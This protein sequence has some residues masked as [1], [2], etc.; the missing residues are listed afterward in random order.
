VPFTAQ[1]LT[2]GHAPG[3]KIR[4]SELIERAYRNEG[5][6]AN[7]VLRMTLVIDGIKNTL[8][9]NGIQAQ[10]I[11]NRGN[12]EF[13]VTQSSGS[14][15][16]YTLLTLPP[17]NVFHEI[18]VGSRLFRGARKSTSVDCIEETFPVTVDKKLQGTYSFKFISAAGKGLPTDVEGTLVL[19]EKQLCING[20]NIESGYYAAPVDKDGVG[21]IS[22]WPTAAKDY[23]YKLSSVQTSAT[24]KL[25]SLVAVLRSVQLA[26]IV[27]GEPSAEN[28]GALTAF[29]KISDV[30]TCTSTVIFS[31]VSPP[32]PTLTANE[33]SIFDLAAELI[34]AMF[35]SPGPVQTYQGYT[36]RFFAKSSVYIGIKDGKIFGLGGSFGPGIKELGTTDSVLK[37]LQ[38]RKKGL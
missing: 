36:Y 32:A 20:M 12:G 16:T 8:C 29:S 27:N 13:A 26:A 21:S 11:T 28:V 10:T 19:G 6:P 30:T 31:S 23:A 22:Y 38:D 9:L 18:I 35:A 33:Q 4:L 7:A 14:P 34:P 25:L 15:T 1:V 5:N 17:S 24:D 3:R 2:A 37:Y